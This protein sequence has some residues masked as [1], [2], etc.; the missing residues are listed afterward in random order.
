MTSHLKCFSCG[1]PIPAP[2]APG[3]WSIFC[4]CGATNRITIP[5]QDRSPGSGAARGPSEAS[6]D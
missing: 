3:K 2:V 5:A 4:K 1:R 6:H